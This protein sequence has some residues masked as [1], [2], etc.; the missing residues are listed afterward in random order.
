MDAIVVEFS[1]LFSPG[2]NGFIC[3]FRFFIKNVFLC[4]PRRTGCWNENFQ[5]IVKR[6]IGGKYYNIFIFYDNFFGNTFLCFENISLVF[7]FTIYSSALNTPD[8][9]SMIRITKHQN[10]SPVDV[11]RRIPSIFNNGLNEFEINGMEVRTPNH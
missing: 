9:N 10:F 2:I 4:N 8:Q 1:K 7:S 5:I 6:Y 11:C 3:F